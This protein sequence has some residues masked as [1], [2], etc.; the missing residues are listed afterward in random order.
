MSKSPESFDWSRA[1]Q[2]LRSRIDRTHVEPSVVQTL[3]KGAS[4]R[5]LIACSGGA[6]SV[7][8]LCGLKVLSA[9]LGI[10]LA[11]AH[12]NHRWRASASD[13]DAHF[14]R[15]L[16]KA[17]ELPYFEA[18]R[19][20]NEAAFTETTARALRLEFLRSAANSFGSH[21]IAFGHQLD[22]IIETQ[23]QRIAR[24]VGSEGLAAPR[25]VSNFKGAPSHIRPFI[26]HRAVDIRMT[27]NSTAIPWR[28]DE[29]NANTNIARNALRA[30]VIPTLTEALDRDPAI[31][32]ARSRRLLEEDASALNLLARQAVPDAF[33]GESVLDRAQLQP[34]PTALL[35]RALSAWL[36]AHGLHNHFGASAMDTL[37]KVI[38]S[39]QQ[40]HLLSAGPNFIRVRKGRVAVESIPANPAFTVVEEG[41]LEPGE[42]TFLPRGAIIE[43]QIVNVTEDL[44]A[45]LRSGSVNPKIETFA[46][47]PLSLPLRV[48]GWQPGDRY[49]PLGA[50]GNKKL[51]DWFIDRRIPQAERKYI[52]VVTTGEG[53]I[54]WVPGF[55][56]AESL[57]IT[58]STNRALRLTYRVV[59]P[60]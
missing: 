53:D 3:E 20:K 54:I 50:P 59:D 28:E 51:K 52:P 24:G 47:L 36:S 31:G 48:R 42:S 37:V 38:Q 32:A 30:E 18:S 45:R 49:Q 1:L 15:T 11:V 40:D 17:L 35:R 4:K 23:L 21:F 6:D 2:R 26:R 7:F 29:S 5:V 46:S 16:A 33:Y 57:K 41:A 22:D 19:P 44:L 55:A 8:L 60:F 12:Y 9:D 56:P 13:L 14:V 39:E 34:I 58:D 43:S 25:P 27:L 10:D